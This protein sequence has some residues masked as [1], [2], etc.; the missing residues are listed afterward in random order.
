MLY[1]LGVHRPAWLGQAG[2]P[3][4]VSFSTMRGVKRLP[5]ALSRWALDSGAYSEITRHGEWRT[6][7][8]NYARAVL[9]LKAM[10]GKLDWAAPQDWT[11]DP[12][13]IAATGLTVDEHQ[14]RTIENYLTLRKLR[15]P[16]IPVLQGWTWG[17]YIR[18]DEAYMKAGVDLSKCTVVGLGSVAGRGSSMM[19]GSLVHHFASEG[20]RLHGFGV[21]FTGL[22]N[23]GQYLASADSTAWSSEARYQGAP[24]DRNSLEY[25]LGWYDRLLGRMHTLGIPIENGEH[26]VKLKPKPQPKPRPKPRP[27]PKPTRPTSPTKAI[28]ELEEVKTRPK[29][30]KRAKRRKPGEIITADELLRRALEEL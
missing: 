21:K 25:A 10:A 16:V 9:R 19:V 11:C 7:P 14:R 29:K 26:G 18:H 8:Q 22:K 3:L 17:D 1:Y 30:P 13:S 2:V 23:F 20:V 5:R 24:G 12:K 28:A 27:R 4:F 15:A 6:S